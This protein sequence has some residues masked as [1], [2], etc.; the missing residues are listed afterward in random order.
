MMCGVGVSDVCVAVTGALSPLFSSLLLFCER[1][2]LWA[3]TDEGLCAL[4]SAG[5]G[6]KLTSLHLSCECCSILVSRLMVCGSGS[7]SVGCVCV[8]VTGD[9]SPL[10]SCRRLLCKRTGLQGRVTDEWLC[11]LASAGCGENLMSLH[12]DSECSC[13]LVF[14]FLI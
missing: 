12:L 5:C 9:L 3:V 8:S 14:L 2:D 11:A 1:A 6:E 13:V 4:A 10:L 7:V